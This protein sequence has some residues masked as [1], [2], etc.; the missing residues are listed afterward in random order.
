MMM[1]MVMKINNERIKALLPPTLFRWFTYS[2]MHDGYEHLIS[3]TFILLLIGLP[4]EL[5][6][7]WY[8]MLA[9]FVLGSILGK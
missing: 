6:H 7:K 9:I 8:R 5:V 4:L 3:N 2:L 1:A